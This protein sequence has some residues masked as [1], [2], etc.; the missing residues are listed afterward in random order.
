M[1]WNH[2]A[3]RSTRVCSIGNHRRPQCQ[4]TGLWLSIEGSFHELWDKQNWWCIHHWGPSP[5]PA[6]RSLKDTA[7]TAS[8]L[9]CSHFPSAAKLRK[10]RKPQEN[11][12]QQMG[13][14]LSV[15]VSKTP[16]RWATYLCLRR[17]VSA[18]GPCGKTIHIKW[19]KWGE[20][21]QEI[22]LNSIFLDSHCNSRLGC[23]GDSAA[24]SSKRAEEWKGNWVNGRSWFTRLREMVVIHKDFLLKLLKL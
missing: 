24:N 1:L 18:S 8:Q 13:I 20:L 16:S 6:P 3:V 2:Q 4:Q 7:W 15:T 22:R 5:Q 11:L 17:R 9:H 10:I 14:S 19:G 21:Y 23:F 12:L